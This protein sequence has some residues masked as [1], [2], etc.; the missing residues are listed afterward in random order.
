[1]PRPGRSG[2][3]PPTPGSD[4]PIGRCTRASSPWGMSAYAGSSPASPTTPRRAGGWAT[5]FA[6]RLIREGHAYHRTFGWVPAAWI[7]HLEQGEL[8]APV[9]PG[10]PLRWLTA[11]EAD[12]LRGRFADAWQITTPHFQIRANVPLA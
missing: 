8:P 12:A 3:R 7:P 2:P 5:P 9:E 10:R 4:W 6:V 11:A 1:M